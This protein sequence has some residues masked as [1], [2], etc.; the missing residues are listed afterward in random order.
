MAGIRLWGMYLLPFVVWPC[1]GL[2]RT[3]CKGWKRPYSTH[4]NT[5]FHKLESCLKNKKYRQILL[6]ARKNP[7]ERTDYPVQTT[8]PTRGKNV[9]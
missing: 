4:T 1:A 7:D 9:D 8:H 2:R 3:S 5:S 6:S